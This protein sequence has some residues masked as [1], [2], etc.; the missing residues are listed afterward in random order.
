MRVW[1]S[2][3]DV[4]AWSVP[5]PHVLRHARLSLTA[6]GR[7]WARGR[8]LTAWRRQRWR[9]LPGMRRDAATPEVSCK[10]LKGRLERWLARLQTPESFG[11]DSIHVDPCPG[12]LRA[13]SP[14]LTYREMG[15]S[16]HVPVALRH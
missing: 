10:P 5:E 2:D 1:T 8:E 9:G 3:V 11:V 16:I 6:C 4:V 7:G 13:F 15:L 14:V 12:G